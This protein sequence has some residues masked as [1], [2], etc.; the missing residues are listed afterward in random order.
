MSLP[1]FAAEASLASPSRRY[2]TG[3]GGMD[4]VGEHGVV[5]QQ[6]G[7]ICTP[8]VKVPILGRKR[9]CCTLFPFR[10]RIEDC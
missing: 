8:C 7:N 1:G 3:A 10:C 6:L 9:A 4:G 2:R 5:P